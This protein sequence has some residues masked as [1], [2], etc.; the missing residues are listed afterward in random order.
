MQTDR[1]KGKQCGHLRI[2]VLIYAHVSFLRQTL[3]EIF[4]IEMNIEAIR[5]AIRDKGPPLKVAQTRLDER[6]RRP[7]VELCRDTAQI[8]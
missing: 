8:R 4:Q 1:R 5:K 7:N 6:T 2:W 3:Q